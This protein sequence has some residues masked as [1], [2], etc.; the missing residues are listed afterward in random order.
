MLDCGASG[1]YAT[2]RAVCSNTVLLVLAYK[3]A[4]VVGVVNGAASGLRLDL[5]GVG[6]LPGGSQ[7]AIAGVES[8]RDQAEQIE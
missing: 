5:G 8:R 1:L 6:E 3:H 2:V 4:V 7:G